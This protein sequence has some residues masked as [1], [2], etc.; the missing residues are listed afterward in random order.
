MFYLIML[1]C[2]KALSELFI[3]LRKYP[4]FMSVS[5]RLA[6]VVLR[7]LYRWFQTKAFQS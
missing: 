4:Y 7:W 3:L 2:D 5:S 1:D 6:A